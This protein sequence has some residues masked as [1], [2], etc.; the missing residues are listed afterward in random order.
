M[1]AICEIHGE[2]VRLPVRTVVVVEVGSVGLDRV[3]AFDGIHFNDPVVERRPGWSRGH[4][5]TN[6]FRVAQPCEPKLRD[7]PWRQ[8]VNRP[9]R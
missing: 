5:Y 9:A 1:S 3:L 2:K 7:G 6:Q 8:E 4:R